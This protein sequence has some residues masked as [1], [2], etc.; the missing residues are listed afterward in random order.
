MALQQGLALS[1]SR[2]CPVGVDRKRK[3]TDS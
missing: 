2:L 3:I 1:L